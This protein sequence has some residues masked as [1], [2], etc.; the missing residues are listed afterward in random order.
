[1]ANRSAL[2]QKMGWHLDCRTA[3]RIRISATWQKQPEWS[4]HQVIA[5]LTP[6]PLLSIRWVQRILRECRRG[7]PEE[8]SSPRRTGQPSRRYRRGGAT[9]RQRTRD[10]RPHKVLRNRRSAL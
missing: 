10:W 9:P 7:V 8:R 4:S 6:E 5:K 2:H 3:L 1:A